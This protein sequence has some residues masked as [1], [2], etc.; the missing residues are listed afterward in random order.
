MTRY[1]KYE[2]DT[3]FNPDSVLYLYIY[4]ER[5]SDRDSDS[6]SDREIDIDWEIKILNDW[7]FTLLRWDPADIISRDKSMT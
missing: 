7:D 1:C 3:V 4:I 6:D 5:E 2:K